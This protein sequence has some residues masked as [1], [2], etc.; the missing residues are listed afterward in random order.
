M[1]SPAASICSIAFCPPAM[2]AMGSPSPASA[3]SISRTRVTPTIRAPLEPQ[4]RCPAAR[5]FSRAYLHHLFK[6]NE[7]LGGTLL[8]IVNLFYYQ[9][10]TAGARDAIA[11]RRFAEYCAAIEEQWA[12]KRDVEDESR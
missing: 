10:L 2:A 6:A 9:D 4:T 7:A 11:Q 12:A 5:G 3:R 8:S 1:R